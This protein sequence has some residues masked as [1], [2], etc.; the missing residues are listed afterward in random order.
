[1]TK[2]AIVSR[3]PGR[4]RLRDPSLR[5]P[6]DNEALRTE[7]G[8]WDGMVAVEGNPATGS[9]LLCYDIAKIP[10]HEMEARVAARLNTHLGLDQPEAPAVAAKER[11]TLRQMNRAAKIGM[12]G[13]LTGSLLALAVGKKLHAALGA[14]H[15]AFLMV[16][17]ANHRKKLLQ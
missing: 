6:Q 2:S 7:L 1:M 5:P 3:L 4:L 10:A 14:M 11:L 9:L 13:S 8:G 12:I 17:I 16:H 15:V